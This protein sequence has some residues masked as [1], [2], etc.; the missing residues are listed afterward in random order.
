MVGWK[1]K[2]SSAAAPIVPR[3]LQLQTLQLNSG[4]GGGIGLQ[5]LK[6]ILIELSG[7]KFRKLFLIGWQKLEVMKI[8]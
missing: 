4:K 2:V 1:E 8:C 6:Q 7:F 3:P 5:I